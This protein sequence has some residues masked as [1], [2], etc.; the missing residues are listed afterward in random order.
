MGG[1]LT[2][3]YADGTERNVEEKL[4]EQDCYRVFGEKQWK[5]K[6]RHEG[7]TDQGDPA[8]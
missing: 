7:Y 3:R 1:A 8:V 5:D 4:G 6:S 2:T